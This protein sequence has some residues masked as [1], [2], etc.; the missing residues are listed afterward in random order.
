M[1]TTSVMSCIAI[2]Y[3]KLLWFFE[4]E[5]REF[6]WGL[7]GWFFRCQLGLLTCLAVRWL[8]SGMVEVTGPNFSQVVKAENQE[9]EQQ[10]QSTLSNLHIE[11]ANI[12]LAISSPM[13]GHWEMTRHWGDEK[14]LGTLIPLICHIICIRNSSKS[15]GCSFSGFP[16][17]PSSYPEFNPIARQTQRAMLA[18]QV[19]KIPS[20]FSAKQI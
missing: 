4:S 15:R 10:L 9:N 12:S 13:W 17:F 16:W 11:F 5:C 3:N 20:H 19:T 1:Y 14:R 7:T 18:R 2:L 8:S 6:R